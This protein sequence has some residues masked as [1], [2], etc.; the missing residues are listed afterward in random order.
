LYDL[1][2]V[3]GKLQKIGEILNWGHE[4]LAITGVENCDSVH[5]LHYMGFRKQFRELIS[6]FPDNSNQT[7]VILNQLEESQNE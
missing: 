7:E 3:G 1:K 2:A 4:S 6:F 5:L